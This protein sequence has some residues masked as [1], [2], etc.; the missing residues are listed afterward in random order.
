M[1]SHLLVI[2]PGKSRPNRNFG[3]ER[4]WN[5]RRVVRRGETH[6]LGTEDRNDF[7]KGQTGSQKT[8]DSKVTEFPGS[9]EGERQIP[10]RTSRY[11]PA[12]NDTRAKNQGK[13][14]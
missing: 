14:H 3:T 13:K 4:H 7:A 6:P 12:N 1:R 2:I 5:N 10:G 8:T 9:N 11:G